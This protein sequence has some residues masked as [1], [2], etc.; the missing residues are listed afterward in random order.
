MATKTITKD[1][2]TAPQLQRPPRSGKQTQVQLA[3]IDPS[4]FTVG[5]KV[6]D[7]RT[8]GTKKLEINYN[9]KMVHLGFGTPTDPRFLTFDCDV[10][11]DANGAPTGDN[12][13]LNINLADDEYTAMLAVEDK[14]KELVVPKVAQV[15]KGLS[16]EVFLAQFK[17]ALRGPE[18]DE[19]GNLK[20]GPRL[21]IAVQHP[22]EPNADGKAP[23]L[24]TLK[25]CNLTDDG[26]LSKLINIAIKHLTRG[27]AVFGAMMIFRG[28]WFS[29]VGWGFK[30]TLWELVKL[31]N[32]SD[33]TKKGVYLHE[34]EV[35]TSMETVLPEEDGTEGN[36]GAPADNERFSEHEAGGSDA[37]AADAYSN[38]QFQP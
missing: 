4:L 26:K 21:R 37:G 18:N 38:G 31:L 2:N 8:A 3:D 13:S 1:R 27:S 29:A 9:G 14:I 7:G 25:A 6:E 10:P 30:F 11:R 28:I 5:A 17:S 33:E 35:D 34:H 15:K 16:A 24:P 20:Y 23:R 36:H 19:D 22:V 32:L 12:Y